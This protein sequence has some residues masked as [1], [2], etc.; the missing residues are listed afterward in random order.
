[1]VATLDSNSIKSEPID[2]LFY[3]ADKAELQAEITKAIKAH[4]NEVNL[5]YIDTSEVTD[6]SLLFQFKATFN[7]DISNVEH[8]EG[9]IHERYV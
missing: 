6:M 8:L 7:E 2:F 9:K 4:G 1:M 5:N 3:V